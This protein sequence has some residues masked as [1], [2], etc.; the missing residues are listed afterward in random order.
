M[1]KS[2]LR[3]RYNLLYC[4]S[5]IFGEW[6]L[7]TFS[8]NYICINMFLIS[9]NAHFSAY[10]TLSLNNCLIKV[11]ADEIKGGNFLTIICKNLKFNFILILTLHNGTSY[12]GIPGKNTF[13]NTA[14]LYKLIKLIT[15]YW[16]TE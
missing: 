12:H 3:K 4:T 10:L 15:K 14:A 16:R 2:C 9:R 8:K 7:V 1:L 6:E 5:F 13:S 11:F